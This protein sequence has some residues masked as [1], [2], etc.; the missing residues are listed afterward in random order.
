[1]GRKGI[2][3]DIVH[4]GRDRYGEIAVADCDGVR[5]L[6]FGEILQSSIRLD[7]PDT[8]IEDYSRAMMTPLIFI[9]HVHTALL[10][11]LGG[12]SLLHFLISFLPDCSLHVVELRRQVIDVAR[13][14]FVLPVEDPNI[15]I[16]HTAGEDFLREGTEKGAHYDLILVDAFDENGPA[17]SMLGENFLA[18]CRAALEEGGVFA[19]NLWRRPKDNF[20]AICQSLRQTFGDNTLELVIGEA[21]WNA[22]VLGCKKDALFLNLPSYRKTAK[23]LQQKCGIDFPRYLKL[24]YWQNSR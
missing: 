22:I 2:K 13:D 4:W 8:L 19:I 12:G 15:E 5:S 6:Y 20:A 3:G 17:A 11:G 7:R 23:V 10:I 21:Y 18:S 16:F 1:M 14:F 9:D 24:L